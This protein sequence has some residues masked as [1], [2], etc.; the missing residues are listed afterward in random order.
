MHI[1]RRFRP[2]L[3][4]A[5]LF[6]CPC[7]CGDTPPPTPPAQPDLWE[8]RPRPDSAR[9]GPPTPDSRTADITI[10]VAA[11]VA[12]GVDVDVDVADSSGTDTALGYGTSVGTFELVCYWMAMEADHPGPPEV[13]LEDDDGEVLATVSLGFAD[14]IM[15]E[16]TGELLDGRILNLKN[17]CPDAPTGWC[18]LEVDLE[19][20]PYGL[21][22]EVPLEPFRSVALDPSHDLAGQVLYAPALD[23]MILPTAEFI[24]PAHDGCLVVADTGWSLGVEQVD[25]YVYLE[26][27]HSSIGDALDDDSVEL[28]RDSPHCP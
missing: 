6:L 17:E 21:G 2:V 23:G 15:L 18:Y 9:H 1:Q 24:G 26:G 13:A 27:Y 25:L 3:I 8:G 28:Y 7:A 11:D 10:D 5:A 12:M 19:E 16:G 14:A 22:S 20:A 4:I